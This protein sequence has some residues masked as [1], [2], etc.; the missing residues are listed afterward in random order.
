MFI[1]WDYLDIITSK[2]EDDSRQ[3]YAA[4]LLEGWVTAD[5]INIYWGNTF[6]H[7]CDGRA[8]LCAQLNQYVQQNKK[9]IM[10]Q[11]MEKN[12][13]DAYWHQVNYQ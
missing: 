11:V 9:W 4:G 1:R 6:Q 2:K 8:D 13:F 7:F 5:L 10:A 12:G 3:A